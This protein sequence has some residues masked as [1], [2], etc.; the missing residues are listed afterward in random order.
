VEYDTRR[1]WLTAKPDFSGLRSVTKNI[2]VLK[3]RLRHLLVDK[4]DLEEVGA[5]GGGLDERNR[6]G[7]GL[8]VGV[9]MYA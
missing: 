7:G 9:E 5:R 8:E 1:P 3:S 6:W 2:K 4:Q